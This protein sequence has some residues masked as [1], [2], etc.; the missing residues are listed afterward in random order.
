MASIGIRKAKSSDI[1][2]VLNLA[3]S[4]H[5][6]HSSAQFDRKWKENWLHNFLKKPGCFALLA[7]S[8]VPVGYLLCET[9][10]EEYKNS[11]F[12]YVREIYV[13]E[14]NRRRSTGSKLMQLALKFG[15]QNN[16]KY[17]TLKVR[18]SNPAIEF[19]TK[20][21]LSPFSTELRCLL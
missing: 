16:C 17:V 2:I 15:K 1:P 19:F 8:D 3:K 18:Y 12:L 20:N 4:L 11:A 13:S 14:T 10:N 5:D 7:E 21:G 9:R 6:L